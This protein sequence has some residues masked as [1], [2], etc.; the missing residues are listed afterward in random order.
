MEHQYAVTVCGKHAGKVLVQRHGLY[1][2]FSCKCILS[3]DTIYRL[4]VS[5]G[6]V[7]ES[8]GILVPD[9]GSFKLNT[10]L[11]VKRIGE[12]EMTFTLVPKQE[13]LSDTFVRISP[14]EPFAYI[15]RLKSSFLTVHHGQQ[16][17]CIVKKQE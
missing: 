3:G 9:A 5:C 2:M 16:G 13:P 1:Y 15:S 14:E 7:C 6:T 4:V 10:K 12:G 11:P 8:L 17:I